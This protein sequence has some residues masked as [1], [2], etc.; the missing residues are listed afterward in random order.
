[1][2]AA[3]FGD[4]AAELGVREPGDARNPVASVHAVL[5][6]SPAPW[7]LV[8][9][10]APDQ[11]SVAEFLPPAGPGRVL[12]T[13]RNQA[14]TAGQV[15][16]VPVLDPKVAA[17]FL[18]TRSRDPDRESAL[19]LAGQLGGLPLALEQAAVTC[20]PPG[21]TWPVTWHCSAGDVVTC[22]LAASLRAMARRWRPP[23]R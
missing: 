16:Q 9:D 14:W 18:V 5:A 4:L 12:I 19:E 2:L 13:S 21:R 1:M 6:V 10:N 22:W 7:L 3:R 15:L 17:D 23:G 20:G 8:F 11:D